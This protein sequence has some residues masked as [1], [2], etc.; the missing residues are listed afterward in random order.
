MK[1]ILVVQSRVTE[2]RIERER[3]NFRRSIGDAATV[4]FLSS[5]DEKLA[6]S[7][8]GDLLKGYDA[9]I[10]GGSADFDFHGGRHPEDP[11]RLMSMIILSR[12]RNIVTYA[13]E[14]QVP[15]LGVCFGH[16]IVAQMHGG[17]VSND[18]E[19]SKFGS[20]EVQLTEA[21]KNDPLFAQMPEKFIAQYAHRDSA[22]SMPTGAELLA[23]S[24]GCKY[25]VLRYGTTT[26]TVQFHP[27]LE[28]FDD[29]PLEYKP[30]PEA[31]S[32]I[33]KWLTLIG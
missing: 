5:V 18:R 12:A 8:P 7:S 28:T 33:G 16:Q 14:R 23:H 1:K 20:Y 17:M 32:L 13:M 11:V 26:Y 6:W 21:G 25:S 30:S 19:Q 31:S 10:F 22:T 24:P 15:I 27:E 9:V 29:M 4:G 2:R 3:E